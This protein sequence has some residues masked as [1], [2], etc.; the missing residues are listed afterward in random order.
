MLHMT[1]AMNDSAGTTGAS[2]MLPVAEDL[3]GCLPVTLTQGDDSCE[4]LLVCEHARRDMPPALAGL[5]L[6]DAALR[7]HIAWDPGALG[8]AQELARLWQAPLVAGGMS[9]LVYD[10]NRPPQSPTA[11]PE[12]SEIFEV[13]GNRGLGDAARA[14]RVVK[15]YEPFRAALAREIATRRGAL[16]LMVTVH[17]FTPVFNGTP[18]AVELGILHGRDARF[19]E[20]MLAR[21]PADIGWDVQL[22]EPYS[23]ADGVAHTLDE[24]GAANGLLNVMLEI[25]ND[26][27]ETEAQQR[28]WAARLAPWI[29][30]TLKEMMQ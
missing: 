28:D 24:Q 5:G 22:N 4:I 3:S 7:S 12:R 9:R 20:I 15:V 1:K 27:I 23:A 19:A 8:V 16:R 30:A 29:S 25:R 18:R 11:I 17:S 2:G 10:L 14:Q 6:D 13:P 21:K 26:L